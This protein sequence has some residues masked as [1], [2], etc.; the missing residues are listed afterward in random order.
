MENLILAGPALLGGLLGLYFLRR[1]RLIGTA[2]A[3]VT[4]FSVQVLHDPDMK[5]MPY[6]CRIGKRIVSR[7]SFARRTADGRVVLCM[8]VDR[9]YYERVM[10][11]L[12][13]P[14]YAAVRVVAIHPLDTTNVELYVR[15]D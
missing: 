9:R 13:E 10:R 8:W 4:W 2:N 5:D 11:R 12:N 7:V 3:I 15:F 14:A 6:D 1:A